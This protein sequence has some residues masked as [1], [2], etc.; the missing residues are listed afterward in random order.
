MKDDLRKKTFQRTV[1]REKLAIRD[2]NRQKK[3]QKKKPNK[4][5]QKKKPPT[6]PVSW[7]RKKKLWRVD[8][9]WG[10]VIFTDYC[11]MIGEGNRV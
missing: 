10:R 7:A 11:V 8:E 2:E 1:V 6:K 9:E 5:K 4:K 3:K